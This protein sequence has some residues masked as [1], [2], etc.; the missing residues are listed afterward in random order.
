MSDWDV[1]RE[2]AFVRWR[3]LMRAGASELHDRSVWN[4]YVQEAL[5]DAEQRH[6][7]LRIDILGGNLTPRLW[8]H[9]S[10]Q[11]CSPDQTP[12][13]YRNIINVEAQLAD[14]ES[15]YCELRALFTDEEIDQARRRKHHTNMMKIKEQLEARIR[16]EKRKHLKV[17]E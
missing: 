2:A 17:I 12:V 6:N 7:D 3:E 10:H 4:V 11:V 14:M 1:K 13:Y 8:R 16:D 15:S 9:K 5:D